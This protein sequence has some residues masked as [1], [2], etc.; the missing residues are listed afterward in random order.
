[1]IKDRNRP[2]RL[3][4]QTINR[5]LPCTSLV[6]AAQP[7]AESASRVQDG[8]AA[9]VGT[10]WILTVGEISTRAL[11]GLTPDDGVELCLYLSQRWREDAVHA[12]L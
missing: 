4:T 5:A 8:Q 7:G 10:R 11:A 3:M 1:M 6:E 12:L 2:C 9:A